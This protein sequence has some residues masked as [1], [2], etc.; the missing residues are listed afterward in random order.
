MTGELTLYYEGGAHRVFKG[1][2]AF[3][4]AVNVA[5]NGK[6]ESKGPVR[7]VAF[8]LG[9]AGAPTMEK[10]LPFPAPLST[11]KEQKVIR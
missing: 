11:E 8:F 4:E 2:E 6:N 7:L 1:G 9:E 5:H 3:A 10:V